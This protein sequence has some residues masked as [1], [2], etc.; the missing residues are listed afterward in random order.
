[1]ITQKTRK[2]S[3]PAGTSDKAIDLTQLVRQK[4]TSASSEYVSNYSCIFYIDLV[5]C[6]LKKP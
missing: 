1:M 2:Q 4:Q 3:E 6:D 5:R